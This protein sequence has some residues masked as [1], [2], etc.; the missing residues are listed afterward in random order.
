MSTV[1]LNKKQFHEV[2][3]NTYMIWI[4]MDQAEKCVANIEAISKEPDV[5]RY[6]TLLKLQQMKKLATS[7]REELNA[8]LSNQPDRIVQ[9]G[10]VSDNIETQIK[11]DL[12]YSLKKELNL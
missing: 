2:N 11:T 1:I 6:V 9:F 7:F 4:Y 5:R 8:A 3:Q 10:E 12:Y